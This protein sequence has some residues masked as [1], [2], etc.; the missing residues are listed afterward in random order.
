MTLG[1]IIRHPLILR[2]PGSTDRTLVDSVFRSH[3]LEPEPVFESSS[4]HAI[5]QAVYAG[6][7]VAFLPREPV[8]YIIERAYLS[9]RGISDASFT[10]SNSIV[11][12]RRKRL[13]PACSAFIELCREKA[14]R[15]PEEGGFILFD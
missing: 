7:G 12:H 9:T 3:G 1:E 13:S 2:E 6:I 8:M 15:K 5:L 4:V 14:R 10:K 11:M